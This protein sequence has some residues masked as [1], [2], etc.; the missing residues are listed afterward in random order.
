MEKQ[1]AER[2]AK[3]VALLRVRNTFLEDLH[4]GIYPSSKAGDYSDVNVVTPYG[5][6]PWSRLSRFSDDEMR[7]L[8]KEVVNKIFTVLLR[9]DDAEFV[10]RMDNFTRVMTRRWAKPENLTDWFTGWSTDEK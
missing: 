10:T 6:I 8:M 1:Q 3:D 9:L 4:A 7:R 2:L 5:E